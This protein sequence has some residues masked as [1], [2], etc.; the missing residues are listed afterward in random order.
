M[1]HWAQPQQG[2]L[3]YVALG[4]SAGVGVGVDDPA[5]GYVGMIA[6]RLAETTGETVRVVNLSVSGA[7]AKD[8]LDRQIP[9]LA[10]MPAPDFVTCVI[11]GND[12]AWTGVFRADDFK[13]DMEMIAARLPH[14][15]VMGSVPNFMHWPYENRARKANRA[16][17]QAASQYGHVV[18]DIHSPTTR[19]SFRGYMETFA[20][21]WFHPNEKGHALWADAIWDQLSDQQGSPAR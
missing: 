5:Q 6:Q 17:Q 20:G 19:L 1:K 18:A 7:K 14:G 3:T 10:E 4:D 13:H 9:E 21:D 2:T 12:V 16:I 8:V 11:G 15:A